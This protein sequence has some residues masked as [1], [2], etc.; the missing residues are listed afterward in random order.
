M[1]ERPRMN[2]R[3]DTIAVLEAAIR[4]NVAEIDAAFRDRL[5]AA[6]ANGERVL[7]AML[8][9]VRSQEVDARTAAYRAAYARLAEPIN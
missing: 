4:R 5:E 8:L 6:R 1:I 3:V 9:E 7:L 2:P